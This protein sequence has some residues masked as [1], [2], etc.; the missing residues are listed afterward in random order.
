MLVVDLEQLI[1]L[2]GVVCDSH[3]AHSGDVVGRVHAKV[4]RLVVLLNDEVVHSAN[5]STK[6]ASLPR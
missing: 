6:L 3:D 4:F 1:L 5:C 2:Q